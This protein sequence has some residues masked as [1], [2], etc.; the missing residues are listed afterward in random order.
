[1][2]PAKTGRPDE[3]GVVETRILPVTA[4]S[5]IPYNTLA[6][7]RGPSMLSEGPI[8][9]P[10]ESGVWKGLTGNRKEADNRVG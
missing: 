3:D 6:A 8:S 4:M 9:L 5:G 2:P 10:Y 7:N 1:M